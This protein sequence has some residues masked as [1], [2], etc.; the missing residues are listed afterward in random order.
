[1]IY[2]SSNCSKFQ[3]PGD[4][5]HPLH[6]LSLSLAQAFGKKVIGTC[7]Y[8]GG[9]TLAGINCLIGPGEFQNSYHQE[10]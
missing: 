5:V 2:I 10:T 7:Q 9:G 6:L 4:N 3:A 1:M 8:N